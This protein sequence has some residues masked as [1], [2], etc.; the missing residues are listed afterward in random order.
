M[1]G[2]SNSFLLKRL[3][4][5][6]GVLPIGF[7]LT[8]HLV[9]N[10]SSQL[11]DGNAFQKVVRGFESLPTP[12]LLAL[13]ILVL[14]VPI[15]FHT[16]YGFVVIFRGRAEPLR[17]RYARNWFYLWQRISGVA[18]FAFLLVHVWQLTITPR[19]TPAELNFQLVR[20]VLS[21]P[22]WLVVYVVGVLA[23]VSHFAN[24]LWS[25]CITWGI[26]IGRGSQRTSAVVFAC[27]GLALFLIGMGSLQGFLIHSPPPIGMHGSSLGGI[28]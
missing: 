20:G 22:G 15:L 23:A 21:N 9:L 12:A 3:F 25:F 26:T 4:S 13:E 24:G 1:T 28:P 2:P 14:A 18:I 10:F 27:V 6:S 7:Y 16:I 11:Q 19:V 5:L 8:Q 17:Y